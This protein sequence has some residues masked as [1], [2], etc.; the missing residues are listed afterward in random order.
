[1]LSIFKKLSG[2]RKI[3]TGWL[4]QIKRQQ[5]AATKIE[6]K[7]NKQ[8]LYKRVLYLY[9]CF[10]IF[11]FFSTPEIFIPLKILAQAGTGI[12]NVLI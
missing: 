1:M 7:K 6:K 11:F 12:Y 4:A 3:L 9:T 5:K 10:S 2:H 8:D